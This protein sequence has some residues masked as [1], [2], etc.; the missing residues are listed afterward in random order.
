MSS[1]NPLNELFQL[2]T[3]HLDKLKAAGILPPE[4]VEIL[5]AVASQMRAEIN[6][7]VMDVL[8]IPEAED[9]ARFER[10]KIELETKLNDDTDQP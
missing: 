9:A 1:S 5:K 8:S 10:L 7:R 4:F 2:A 3:E 6:C